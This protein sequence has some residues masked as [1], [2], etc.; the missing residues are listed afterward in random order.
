MLCNK[1][2][3]G[4]LEG[5]NRKIKAFSLLALARRF[6]SYTCK[7]MQEISYLSHAPV[8]VNSSLNPFFNLLFKL[9]SATTTT[10]Q[11]ITSPVRDLLNKLCT[12]CLSLWILLTRTD[13]MLST[14]VL[15][16]WSVMITRPQELECLCLL[17]HNIGKRLSCFLPTDMLIWGHA[18]VL[19]EDNNEI[20]L[21]NNQSTQ[22]VDL[23]A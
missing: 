4:W 22:L 18:R 3:G 15:G 1:P 19:L 21:A 7:I 16:K 10:T 11:W 8:H 17:R 20:S 5:S 12:L 13:V 23:L 6:A 14:S 2:G 9:F